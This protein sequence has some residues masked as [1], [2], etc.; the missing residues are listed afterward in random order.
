MVAQ[1]KSDCTGTDETIGTITNYY[2]RSNLTGYVEAFQSLHIEVNLL[3]DSYD[4]VFKKTLMIINHSHT[5]I[6]GQ[7][8]ILP[9]VG[10][11]MS[12]HFGTVS[13]LHNT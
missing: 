8:S 13:E 10:Q 5:V 6:Q 1:I 3:T 4:S 9:R 2:L 11:L 7:R 12:T